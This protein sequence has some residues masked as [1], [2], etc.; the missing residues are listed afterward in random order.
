MGGADAAG[1]TAPGGAEGATAVDGGDAPANE[2]PTPPS[3]QAPEDSFT[4]ET[5]SSEAASGGQIAP[6]E[7]PVD[8]GRDAEAGPGSASEGAAES[9]EDGSVGDGPVFKVYAGSFPSRESADAAKADLLKLGLQGTIIEME[10][11]HLLHVA[12]LDSYEAAEALKAE[13][14]ASGFGSAFATLKR[15]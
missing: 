9:G 15:R 4:P 11:E 7:T 13:L 8:Q 2:A 12:T 1:D 10:L 14:V 3:E 5:G 6:P